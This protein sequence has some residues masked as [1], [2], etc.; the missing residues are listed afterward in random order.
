MKGDKIVSKKIKFLAVAVVLVVVLLAVFAG[1]ACTG[2]VNAD[3]DIAQGR[4]GQKGAQGQN[5]NGDCEQLCDGD[6]DGAG[7]GNCN[8]NC[9]GNCDGDCDGTGQGNCKGDCDGERDGTGSGTTGKR[10]SNIGGCC[11]GANNGTLD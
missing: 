4:F 1:A 6:C 10:W 11:V 3:D 9:N 2:N 7:Q 5:Y 8:G